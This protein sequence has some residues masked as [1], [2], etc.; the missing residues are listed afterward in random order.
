[1]FFAVVVVPE[2]GDNKD[3]LTL[4]E[5]FVDGTLDAL[6][7][8]FLVLVIVSTVKETVANFDGLDAVSLSL[9]WA[10]SGSLDLRCRLYQRLGQLVPSKDRS[11]RE[12]YHGQKPA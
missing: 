12:A 4:D 1:M 5:S 10:W 6:S 7:R 9:L 8:F 2:L 11:L 3:I